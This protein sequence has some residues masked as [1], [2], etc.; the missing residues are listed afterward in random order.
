MNHK[1]H[2]HPFKEQKMGLDKGHVI[3]DKE[4]YFEYIRLKQKVEV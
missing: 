4:F 2:T 3:I 1:I